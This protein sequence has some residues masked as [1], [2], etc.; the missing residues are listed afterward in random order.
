MTDWI[1]AGAH[2][3]LS[4]L[5]RE[6]NEFEGVIAPGIKPKMSTTPSLRSWD[7]LPA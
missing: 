4:L 5:R 1:V 2:V 7:E 6:M 3:Y